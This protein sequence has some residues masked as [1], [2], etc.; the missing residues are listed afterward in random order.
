[1]FERANSKNTLRWDKANSQGKS[2]QMPGSVKDVRQEDGNGGYRI[3]YD[4]VHYTYL[5]LAKIKGDDSLH[6]T[7]SM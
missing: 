3:L 1:M 6:A 4:V 2:V 7:F 5:R